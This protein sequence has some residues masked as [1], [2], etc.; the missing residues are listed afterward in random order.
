MARKVTG[1]ASREQ[2]LYLRH[3]EMCKVLSH[4]TRLEAINMLR[5]G[6]M[7]VTELARRLNTTLGNLSQH[8]IMMRQRGMLA[9]RKEGN[10]VYYHLANPKMLKAF[11]ILREV[12]FEQL[13]REGELVKGHGQRSGR[14]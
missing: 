9:S 11:D 5:E 7:N 6:E 3:A 8:L 14:E 2:E 4:P 1:A 13:E 10:V 12:L